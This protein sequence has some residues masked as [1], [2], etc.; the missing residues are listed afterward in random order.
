MPMSYRHYD[1]V[2]GIGSPKTGTSSLGEAFEILGLNHLGWSAVL[3]DLY[4]KHDLEAILRVA[5]DY[6]A[7]EDGPWNGPDLFYRHGVDFY[8]VLDNKFPGS[9]FIL[10]VRHVDSWV[11]SHEHHFTTDGRKG[12]RAKYRIHNYSEHKAQIVANYHKRNSEVI[13]YFRQRP[14]DFLI[15]NIC[16]G[17]G[18]QKLCEFLRLDPPDI[19]FPHANKTITRFSGN[20]V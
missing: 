2:F 14:D 16:D 17:D 4:L 6:D 1:K 3:W 10:T 20:V 8:K 19:P 7:F 12:R 5:Q 15:M 18:W 13:T 11:K 9:K